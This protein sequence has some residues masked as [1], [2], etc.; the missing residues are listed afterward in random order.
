M[1]VITGKNI[2]IYAGS[3]GTSPIIAAAKSCTISSNCDLVE[4]A[5]STQNTSK[6]YVA[7]RDEWEVSLD[8]LVT[9]GTMQNPVDPFEG[10]LKVRGT[11]TL[12]IVIGGVR[13][14]GTAICQH[15]DIRGE[16]ES[17]GKGSVK[18]K[19]SGP[20]SAPST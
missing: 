15:A 9:T 5:S 4:K 7:G 20:L 2:L 12:S 14:I 17:L 16:V 1:G 8:H 11:Y 13:K 6:E 10:L 3:I 18:F 19:G